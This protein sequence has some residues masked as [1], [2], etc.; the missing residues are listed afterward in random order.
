[1]EGAG[2]GILDSAVVSCP[3]CNNEAEVRFCRDAWG[4]TAWVVMPHGG[5]GHKFKAISPRY[6]AQWRHKRRKREGAKDGGV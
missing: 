6:V 1:M 4:A 3:R 5:C 2:A